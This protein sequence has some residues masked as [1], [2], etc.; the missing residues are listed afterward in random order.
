M[1]AIYRTTHQLF[2]E[3]EALLARAQDIRDELAR[4]FGHDPATAPP[5]DTT[6][7]RP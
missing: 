5:P 3:L 2:D 1:G 6:E 7:Q 4:R